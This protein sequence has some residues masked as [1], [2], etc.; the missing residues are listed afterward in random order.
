MRKGKLCFEDESGAN[1]VVTGNPG[2]GKSRFYLYCIFQ[3][4]LR[5]Q[6][7]VKELAAF[8][9]VLNFDDDFQLYDAETKEFIKL[10]GKE[11]RELRKQHRVLRLIEGTSS[12]LTG[13][14]GASI[15]FA[16]R[17]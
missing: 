16:S 7:E 17:D 9:L 11:V 15:L 4:L 14:K 5:R 13:W 8:D 3:L 10:N 6:K 12:K 1:L 2:T